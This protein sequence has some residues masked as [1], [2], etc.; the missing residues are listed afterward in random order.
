MT[1][2][3]LNA[4]DVQAALWTL[5][6]W[7]GVGWWIEKGP[8]AQG[9]MAALMNRR[10]YEWARRTAEREQRI[11]DAAL[12]NS[13]QSGAAFFASACMFAI[14][15]AAALLGQAEALAALSNDL[16]LADHVAAADWRRRLLMPLGLLVY[17]F[18]KFAWA[19]RL[20]TYNAI[21][22]GSI[23]MP[24]PAGEVG[25]EAEDAAFRAAGLSEQAA[26]NFNRGLRALYFALG[27]LGWLLG[28]WGAAAGAALVTWTLWRREFISHSRAA[29]SRPARPEPETPAESLRKPD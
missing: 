9:T 8:R 15:G 2:A 27:T 26:K 14:G 22:I 29:L 7:V 4:A 16:P 21:M 18:F 10:R 23:P 1:A 12:L 13:L 19:H 11:V 20:F 28:P 25:P 17:A 6:C 24:G 5:V 3:L